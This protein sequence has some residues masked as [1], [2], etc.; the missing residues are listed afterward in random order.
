MQAGRLAGAGYSLP[1]GVSLL[2]VQKVVDFSAFITVRI[3]SEW[4]GYEFAY[5]RNV[6]LRVVESTEQPLPRSDLP[7]LLSREHTLIEISKRK[8]PS[9]LNV[10]MIML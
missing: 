7:L 1:V 9:I 3:Q 4:I 6:G 10:A 8:Q 5:L 2:E